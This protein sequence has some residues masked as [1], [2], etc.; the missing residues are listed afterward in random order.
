MRNLGPPVPL[1]VPAFTARYGAGPRTDVDAA[2]YLPVSR[3]VGADAGVAHLLFAQ[4]FPAAPALMVAGR[5]MV[6]A[7]V[8]QGAA[9]MGARRVRR[10]FFEATSRWS[11]ALGAGQLA[12]LGLDAL[13]A[14][15]APWAVGSGSVGW[16]GQVGRHWQLGAELRWFD[17]TRN[18]RELVVAY[19]ALGRRGGL[20]LQLGLTYHFDSPR[21][22]A[23]RAVGPAR[24]RP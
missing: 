18:G 22:P 12:Y 1:P 4:A 2:L 5:L 17:F 21:A 16:Q 11:W 15:R 10:Q 23:G 6:V 13:F 19:Q 20:G 8:P 14:P 24:R 9:Q 7:S 3:A